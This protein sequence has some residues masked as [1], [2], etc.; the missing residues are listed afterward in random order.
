MAYL[1]QFDF[2]VYISSAPVDNLTWES[3]G[4]V[5]LFYQ[6]LGVELS[7][8]V[9]RLGA[10]KTWRNIGEDQEFDENIRSAIEGSAIFVALISRGYLE[11]SFCLKELQTFCETA[12]KSP[13]GL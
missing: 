4:W 10:I 1:P 12:A 7:R 13:Y 2:D 6:S 11:S 9:G 5:D 3:H 8:R